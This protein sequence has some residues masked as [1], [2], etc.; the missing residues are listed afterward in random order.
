MS[1]R[2]KQANGGTVRDTVTVATLDNGAG[3]KGHGHIAMTGGSG[4][5]FT[6]KA[7]VERH[8]GGEVGTISGGTFNKTEDRRELP[9]AFLFFSAP[10]VP[11]SAHDVRPKRQRQ[12]GE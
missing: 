11:T 6:A 8:S 3:T 5:T 7:T 12:H 4:T 9:S 1:L 2:G 10:R